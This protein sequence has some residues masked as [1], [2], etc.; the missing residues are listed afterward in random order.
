MLSAGSG[1]RRACETDSVL[2]GEA[3]G[4]VLCYPP[5]RQDN[6]RAGVHWSNLEGLHRCDTG[7]FTTRSNEYST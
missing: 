2:V 6:L 1:A 7:W 3:G 4:V 5:M